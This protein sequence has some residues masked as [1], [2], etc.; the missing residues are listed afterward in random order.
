LVTGAHGFVGRHLARALA[1]DGFEVGAIGHGLWGREECRKW[2]IADWHLGDVTIEALSTYGGG[3]DIIFHCAGSGSVAFSMT[4]PYQDFQ[5]SVATTH[6]VLEYIRT[7]CNAA[8]LVLPSS[9]A[10]YGV[11]QTMPIRVTAPL[12]PASAYGTHKKVTE[13]LCRMYGRH[14]GVRSS[15]IRFFS[16]YGIGLRKQLLW[17][18]CRKIADGEVTFSGMGQETRDWIHVEDAASLMIRASK[19]ATADSAVING[20]TGRATQ[21]DAIVRAIA[22]EFDGSRQPEFSGIGR[23]GDP[24]HYQADITQALDWGWTPTRDL[25]EEVRR[26]GG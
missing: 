6:S 12:E 16:I 18:A 23:P 2:G 25:H 1:N 13:D 15:L 14:F 17:D 10:V 5:R 21:I 26:W 3:P 4:N 20:G 11:A 7:V 9:A 19:Y 8:V 24:V 22:D